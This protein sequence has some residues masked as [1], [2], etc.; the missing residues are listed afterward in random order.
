VTVG[1][2]PLSVVAADMNN[3]GWLDILTANNDNTASIALADGSGDYLAPSNLSVGTAPQSIVAADFNRDGRLDFATANFNSS[4]VSVYL[5]DGNSGTGFGSASTIAVG[6]NPYSVAAADVNGDGNPDLIATNFT[7]P[8]N[9]RV[10]PGNGAGSFPAP[11]VNL[12]MGNGPRGL[13]VADLDNDGSLDLAVANNNGAAN[14]VSTRLGTA[15]ATLPVEL[16]SFTAQAQDEAVA[17]RWR[18]ASEQNSAYFE[19]ERS[20]D[21]R[22]FAAIGRVAAQGNADAPTSYAYLDHSPIHPFTHSLYYRLRQVDTDGSAA[23]SPVAVVERSG[24]RP[25]EVY[26]T[27]VVDG[28]LH[29]SYRGPSAEAS[30]TVYNMSG[31]LLRQQATTVSGRGSL[32]VDGLAA[33]WYVARLA[34]A[35]GSYLARFYRP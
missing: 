6:N 22:Q 15:D 34:T 11:V 3:D 14:S 9:V 19:V 10:L 16:V 2:G 31:Q 30:L 1:V 33:G 23:Y 18:T 32:A 12:S 29:F 24:P 13:A 35:S 25:F 21:G 8:G 28:V 20:A 7:N 26:P 27:Q 17:L 4:N 5:G